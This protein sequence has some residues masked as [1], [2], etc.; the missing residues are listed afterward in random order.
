MCTVKNVFSQG[1]YLSLDE[2]GGKEGMVHISELASGW[3][4]NI[5]RHVSEGQKT[6]CKVLDVDK[7]K[8]HID[9][10]IRR[11]KDSQRRWKSEQWKRERKSENL[12][13]QTSERVGEDLETAYELIGFPL[14]EE[15]GDIYTAFEEAA[16]RGRE[17][18]ED[19]LDI[20]EEWIDALFNLIETSVEPPTVE[21]KG[22][23]D[24]KT[25]SS[26]GVSVVR[27]A[28]KAARDSVS[29]SETRVDVSYIGAPTYS[30]KVTAP[31]YKKAEKALRGAA[32]KAIFVVEDDGGMGEFYTERDE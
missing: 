14:K 23:V 21:V 17:V 22:F 27:S 30:I 15:F 31:E 2:Y 3:V 18:L 4:K 13:K 12:L 26:D 16:R 7:E 24:L 20:D 19:A 8:K 28:L 11:V 6:V 32:E 25:P 29:E 1:A 10:S 9:L 5:R